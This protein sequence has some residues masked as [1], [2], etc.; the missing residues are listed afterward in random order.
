MKSFFKVSKGKVVLVKR[1]RIWKLIMEN[2][3]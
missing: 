2:R 1:V 3:V